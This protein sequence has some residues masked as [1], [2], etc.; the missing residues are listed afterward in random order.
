MGITYPISQALFT[1]GRETAS[2]SKVA[3]AASDLGVDPVT[4]RIPECAGRCVVARHQRGNPRRA[5][6]AQPPLGLRHE[7]PPDPWRR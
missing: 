5:E 6:P 2:A 3:H 4:D 7:C 1:R